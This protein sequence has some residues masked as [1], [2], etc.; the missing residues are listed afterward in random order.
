MLLRKLFD[1]MPISTSCAVFCQDCLDKYS[2][3]KQFRCANKLAS[4][5]RELKWH[6]CGAGLKQMCSKSEKPGA[7]YAGGHNGPHICTTMP[8]CHYGGH[9]NNG[10]ATTNRRERV[11]VV[12]AGNSPFNRS[13]SLLL[14]SLLHTNT[15]MQRYKYTNTGERM[16]G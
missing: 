1:K 7:T 8:L 5:V 6:I 9:N 10:Q 14:T 12:R 4:V 11:T 2:W 13:S 15:E 16:T 3:V